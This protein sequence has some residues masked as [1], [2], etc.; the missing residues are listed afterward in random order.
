MAMEFLKKCSHFEKREQFVRVE[1]PGCPR[2]PSPNCFF[3]NSGADVAEWKVQRTSQ[4][5]GSYLRVNFGLAGKN[6][7]Q[8]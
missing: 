7:K 6:V 4:N 8:W 3:S 5:G 2:L 1:Y